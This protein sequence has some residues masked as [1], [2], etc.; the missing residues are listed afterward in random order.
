M[1]P[2]AAAVTSLFGDNIGDNGVRRRAERS[3]DERKLRALHESSL[4]GRHAIFPREVPVPRNLC[5]LVN[6]P[7]ILTW[8]RS[9]RRRF[10]CDR[11]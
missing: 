10:L 8:K 2:V 4:H 3:A 7:R 5:I 9:R 11:V 1:K 6:A